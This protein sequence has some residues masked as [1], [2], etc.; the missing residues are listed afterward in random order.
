MSPELIVPLGTALISGALAAVV[1]WWSGGRAAAA[2]VRRAVLSSQELALRQVIS[3]RVDCYPEMY[4]LLSQLAKDLE[5]GRV[6]LQYLERL[7]PKVD[8][9]DS[10]HALFVSPG[11]L[12]GIWN[13]RV[14]LSAAVRS[15]GESDEI[16]ELWKYIAPAELA[17]RSD[18]GLHG[19]ELVEESRLEAIQ[20]DE[21]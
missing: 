6:D 20:R 8:A 18:L 1:A 3:R 14:A 21:Y 10:A 2:E 12:G 15:N 9:W 16:G 4:Y 11:S 13:F 19:M 7:E 17:L 5:R